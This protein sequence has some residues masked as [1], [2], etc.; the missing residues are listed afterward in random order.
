[1]NRRNFIVKSAALLAAG[2]IGQEVFSSPLAAAAKPNKGRIG[3]QL[4]SVK[5]E[6]P[7]DFKGTLKKLSDMGYSS[8]EAYGFKGEKFIDKITMK[9]LSVILK[10]MGMTLSGSHGG[11]GLL[12]EDINNKDWDFWRKYATEIKSGGGKWAIQASFAGDKNSLDG[13]KKFAAHLNRTGEVCKKYG[14]KFAYHNHHAEFVQVEGEVILDYLLKN[15]DPKLVYFQLDM[16]H[17]VRGGGDCVAYI[18]KYPKR[19]ACWH[20]SD[21]NSASAAY[22]EVGKGSV[23]YKKLFEMTKDLELLTVEQETKGDI[24]ASCKEDFDYLKQFKWTKV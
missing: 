8:V 20:A 19:F 18:Q 4:Y 6:L 3:I 5:D 17:T 14:V 16:G 15:T 23:D 10:D 21:Y 12:S 22:T 2:S 7:K 13:I 11:S 9:E 1:M 24:F